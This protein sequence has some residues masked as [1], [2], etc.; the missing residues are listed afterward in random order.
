MHETVRPVPPADGLRD[1]G[2]AADASGQRDAP[3]VH[4][5]FP[6]LPPA[7]DGIG[8]YT[9]RLAKAL[10]AHCRVTIL[11]AQDAA[12]PIPGV[13][14]RQAFSLDTL[15]GIRAV[16]DA[17]AAAPPDWLVLQYNPFSYGRWGWNPHVPAMLHALK[18]AHPGVRLAVM[19]HEVAPPLLNWRLALMTTWQLAHL[20]RLGRTADLLFVGIEPWVAAFTRWFG[21]T[22][23]HHLPVGS[24]L[25]YQPMQHEQA[26]QR[27]GL[28]DDAPLLGVFGTAHPTRLLGFVRAAVAAARR[29]HPD[30][31]V[32]YVGP[33][34]DTV[35]RLLGDL[36]VHDAGRV[37]PDDAS[38]YFAAMDV[39][40]APFRRG[41]STRRG[42]FMAALQH[43]VPTVSTSGSHT[44]SL[45][46]NAAGQAFV[47]TPDDDADAYALA[48]GPLLRDPDR[49]TAL[50]QAGQILYQS[51]FD[52]NVIAARLVDALA[53]YPADVATRPDA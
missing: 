51:H 18:R 17:V 31:R 21:A 5:L 19:V 29:E 49:R 13:A 15:R 25:P 16:L 24:N 35:R 53:R 10:A 23:V 43:G 42:S 47:L 8:D 34:G 41:V 37:P 32:L 26:R 9:S 30:A 4:L 1:V 11:T 27:L 36:P 6:K 39:C 44:G 50:G 2:Q 46:R 20:R 38:A 52:W 45:L 33:D 14:V 22:P 12:A 28:G 7:P 48:V 3:T 40:L